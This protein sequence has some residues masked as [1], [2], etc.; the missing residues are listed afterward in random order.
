MQIIWSAM[1]IGVV[2]F[3]VMALFVLPKAAADQTFISYVAVG[4]GALAIVASNLLP[5]LIGRQLATQALSAEDLSASTEETAGK[6]A[7]AYQT[8]FI[9][10]MAL[11]EGAAFFALVAFLLEGQQFTLMSAAALWL[12]MLVRF[13]SMSRVASWSFMIYENA[14]LDRT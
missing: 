9:V 7:L 8:K 13:P 3:A 14:T 5:V 12:L 11:L 4:A 10:G 6:L 2:A 1:L